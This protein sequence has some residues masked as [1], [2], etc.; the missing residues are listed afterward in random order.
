MVQAPVRFISNSFLFPINYPPS[1]LH[2]DSMKSPANSVSSSTSPAA[3]EIPP[4]PKDVPVDK[5]YS[6]MF[7]WLVQHATNFFKSHTVDGKEIWDRIGARC[8]IILAIPNGWEIQQQ[9]LLR[10]AIVMSGTLPVD[11][12][13]DQLDFVTEGEASVHYALRH[14]RNPNWLKSGTMFA[15]MDAGGSTVDSTMYICKQV[16]PNILLEE[17]CASECIQAGSVFIDR[18]MQNLLERKLRASRFNDPADIAVMVSKFEETTKRQFGDNAAEYFLRF[19]TSRDNDPRVDIARG[20]LKLRKAEVEEAFSDVI[21]TITRSCSRLLHKGT[22][23]V[24]NGTIYNKRISDLQKPQHLLLVGGFGESVHLQRQLAEYLWNQNVQ[25][26]T[27][28]ESTYVKRHK[29]PSF[30][31]KF[32]Y[33]KKAAAEGAVIWYMKQLVRARAAR[34]T[35]GI[36]VERLFDA[37]TPSHQVRQGLKYVNFRGQT[38]LDGF[39]DPLVIQ[40][41]YSRFSWLLYRP[42]NPFIGQSGRE[43]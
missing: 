2:P 12:E 23:K 21:A 35:F 40:V 9:H 38:C 36:K 10:N 30:L 1:S 4:L 41:C 37:R 32:L 24:R 19:G 14:S 5:I 16:T 11:F 33:R 34:A 18:A 3:L 27:V 8:T 15:L 31:I 20:R 29:S 6:D 43:R 7:R 25:I 42:W 22:A 17:V 39:S 26:V 28:D 13:E